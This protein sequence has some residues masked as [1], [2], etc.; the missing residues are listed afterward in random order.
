M[1]D[2]RRKVILRRA[3]RNHAAY[4]ENER[5][6]RRVKEEQDEREARREIMEENEREVRREEDEKRK[7]LREICG[8]N[9]LPEDRKSSSAFPKYS[10]REYKGDYY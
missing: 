6:T 2:H 9:I 4:E 7:H 1:T 3:E 10:E 8:R 5:E